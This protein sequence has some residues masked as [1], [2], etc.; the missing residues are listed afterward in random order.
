MSHYANFFVTFPTTPITTVPSPY[1][2]TTPECCCNTD[3]DEAIRTI[4]GAATFS[5]TIQLNLDVVD[6]TAAAYRA[7]TIYGICNGI[8]WVQ[9][10][11]TVAVNRY[12]AI[13]LCN[14]FNVNES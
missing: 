7:Q 11:N 5:V 6:N 4:L 12:R 8:L 14:L 10:A 3:I 1:N 9:F 13:P 2:C